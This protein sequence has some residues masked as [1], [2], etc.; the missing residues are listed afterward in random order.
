MW[1]T[2]DRCAK[3]LLFDASFCCLHF[4]QCSLLIR[5]EAP[6]KRLTSLLGVDV[7]HPCLGNS[8]L[9]ASNACSCTSA[10]LIAFGTGF[11]VM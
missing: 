6:M 7:A 1:E 9:G 4:H 5:L 3:Q 10:G 2:A 11:P 8:A